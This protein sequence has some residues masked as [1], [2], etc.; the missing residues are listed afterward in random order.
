[1]AKQQIV[2]APCVIARDGEGRDHYLYEGT[3][4]PSSIPDKEVT[5]LKKL[6]VLGDA[7]QTDSGPAYPDGDPAKSWT[8]NQ[9]K[10]YA[11]DNQI[12]LGDA[13][14]KDDVYAKVTGTTGDETK[15]GGTTP[16]TS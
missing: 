16:P 13:T 14:L 5:R 2:T 1:M 12:D 11:A 7:E 6:G 3:P 8:V 15:D 9:L 10:A 4:V